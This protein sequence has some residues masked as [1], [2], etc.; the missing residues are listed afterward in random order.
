MK[1]RHRV[2]ID[3]QQIKRR[4]A[5]TERALARGG[6]L[7]PQQRRDILAARAEALARRPPAALGGDSIEVVEFV[8]AQRHFAIEA[9]VVREVQ[10]LKELTGVPCTPAF[11]SGI[12]NA[13]GRVIAVIDLKRFFELGESGL[14]DLNKVIILQQGEIEFG[15]LADSVVGTSRMPLAALDPPPSM[16]RQARC[17]RGITAQHVMVIDGARLLGDPDLVVDEQVSP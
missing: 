5:D 7:D 8:I 16:G 4:L 2:A 15:V 13:H 17:L 1:P 9:E 6:E 3:W 12:I 10:A 11:V 14:S